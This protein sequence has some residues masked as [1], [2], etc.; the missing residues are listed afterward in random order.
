LAPF[1]Q[2]ARLVIMRRAELGLSSQTVADRMDTP[3]SVV[4]RIE[5]GQHPTSLETS[6]GSRRR[7]RDGRCSALSSTEQVGRCW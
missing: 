6:A 1:E 5:R 2:L 7:W 3:V 4:S